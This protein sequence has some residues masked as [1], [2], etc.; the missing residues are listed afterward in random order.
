M[1]KQM[2]FIALS[3]LFVLFTSAYP[4]ITSVDE[5]DKAENNFIAQAER[6][7]REDDTSL[8]TSERL[9]KLDVFLES[10]EKIRSQKLLEI[11]FKHPFIGIPLA[12]DNPVNGL[13]YLAENFSPLREFLLRSDASIVVHSML[14]QSR[15]T[16]YPFVEETF[17][18]TLLLRLKAN[19]E[20]SARTY[21]T[22][23]NTPKGTPVQALDR[24]EEL[25]SADKATMKSYTAAHFPYATRILL[26]QFSSFIKAANSVECQPVAVLRNLVPILTAVLLGWRRISVP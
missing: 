5:V 12:Y 17:L 9:A 2:F 25:S 10:P 3:L 6:K 1:S 22:T 11:I 19:P 15:M 14:E 18:K 16:E 23:V 26:F 7:F 20:I 21:I 8:N 13:N 4:S 24:G